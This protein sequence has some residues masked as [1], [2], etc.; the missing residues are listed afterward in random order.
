MNKSSNADVIVIGGGAAG[1]MAAGTAAEQGKRVILIEKNRILGKKML[2]TGKG[3]C[4][5]TN[6]CDDVE[7]L[8]NNVTVNRSFLYSAFYGFTNTDTIDFFNNLGVETKVERGNRVFPV[9]DKS[10]DI[11]NVLTKYV[12]KNGVKVIHDTV[13]E[14]CVNEN[15]CA[16]GV[17]TEKN[18]N[19]TAE[20]IIVATGGMSYQKT[21]STGDGYGWAEKLGH[22]IK[23]IIPSLVPV[24]VNESW[25]YELMGLSLKNTGI[26]VFN[27][28][29]KKIYQDFGELMFAHFGLSGP[30]I[31]SASAHMRPM[32][33]DGYKIVLDLKPAL[34]EQQLDK[35]ILRDFEKYANKDFA[36]ALGDLLPSR[37]IDVIVNLSGIEPHK[38]VNSVTREERM[39]LVKLIKGVELTVKGFCPIEQA[40]ITSGGVSTKEIDP[41]TMQSKKV[42]GLYFAGEIIDVDAYTGG[43]NLQIAFSTGRLAG[44]MC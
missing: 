33:A 36:N 22:T 15:G 3:R 24:E 23:E 20:G 27:S 12:K 28:K 10:S 42:K 19:L 11:V 35:R 34:D 17:I 6:A 25:A 39:S 9:S 41:S 5:V 29:N 2:I 8:I 38:K 14:I 32:I 1:M 21:G 37:L 43:Y 26:T 18:G 44:L 31:L 40:I 7:E 16:C 13:L 4:N 30:T